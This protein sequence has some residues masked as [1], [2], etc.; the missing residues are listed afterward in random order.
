MKS[1]SKVLVALVVIAL[2]F[3][4]VYLFKKNVGTVNIPSKA[5]VSEIPENSA[6]NVSTLPGFTLPPGFSL[7]I[8]AKNLPGARTIL[9]TGNGILVSQTSEG[10]ISLVQDKDHDGVA[11]TKKTVLD[12]LNKPHGLE[13]FCEG[14]SCWLYVAEKDKLSVYDYYYDDETGTA[15]NGKKLL[16]LPASLTDRHFTRSLLWLPPE[17][18]DAPPD[19]LLISVGSSC[20][21]CHEEDSDHATIL[22][23][24]VNTGKKEVYAKGLRNAVFMALNPVDG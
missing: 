16:D 6:N 8:F 13:M 3:F 21:V 12:K 14:G 10:K 17:N 11:E 24:N 9:I 7:H 22:S 20:D 4:G 2:I 18:R 5:P 19:T 1:P 15:R 23:Y